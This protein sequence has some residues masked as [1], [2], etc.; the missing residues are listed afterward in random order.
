MSVVSNDASQSA[1]AEDVATVASGRDEGG[2]ESRWSQNAPSWAR[3]ADAVLQ[4]LDVDPTSGLADAAAERRLKQHGPNEL[5]R[6]KKR[7]I[8]SVAAAQ[9]KS[10]I[11]LLLIAAAA[12][13]FLFGETIEGWA[14][15]V[16]V[17]INAALGFV[18]QLRAVR[19]ME[20]LFKLGRVMCRARRNGEVVEI[21]ARDLVP[22]DVVLLEG[23][24][25]VSADMRLISASQLQADESALTGESLPTAKSVE[26]VDDEAPLADRRSMLY[27]GTG[28]TRGS[29]EGV[30]VGTGVHSELGR[31]SELIS[32]TKDEPT[33]LERRL[34]AL[35]RKL[36]W[37]TLAIA[38]LVVALG[39]IRGKELFLMIE[40]GIA[41][42]VASIPEGLPIVATI[43]LAR[44]VR[45]MARRHALINRLAAVETLGSA[46][47]ICTDKTGTLTENRMTVVALAVE[48][49]DATIDE[50][51]F[52]VDGSALTP[53]DNN[54]LRAAIEVALLCNNASITSDGEAGDPLEVA[55]L[56]V[57][58]AGEID[59]KDLLRKQP[60][61]REEAFDSEVKMMATVHEDGA[62]RSD[63]SDRT[64][65]DY[66]IAVKGAPE[67]VLEAAS[68]I[69]IAD[70]ARSLDDA[71]RDGWS[72]KNEALA[73]EGLR[74]I[75]LA[76]KYVDDRDA[77]PYTDLTFI[78]LVGMADPPRPEVA[79]AVQTCRRAGIQVVMVTGDQLVT[80]KGVAHAVG[81]V[82]T[83]DPAA[84]HGADLAAM[85]TFADDEKARLLDTSIFARV[86]PEQK[87]DLIDLH[88]QNGRIVAMTGD[89]VNDAPALK[90]ADIGIAMGIRG[91]QVAREA[92]DMVLQ[93]DSFATIVAAVEEG[94]I[95]FGNIRRFVFYLLSCNVSEVLVVGLATLLGT[96][97]PILPL[98]ILFLNLVTDIFPA[99]ALG[100]GEGPAR[101]MDVPPRDPKDPILKRRH[102]IDIGWYAGVITLAVL[103][104]LLLAQ[105]WLGIGSERAVTVSFLTLALAQLWHVFN[106][107]SWGSRLISN[108]ITRNRYIWMA[109]GLCLALLG[110]AVY[111]EPLAQVLR[112]V[113]PTSIEWALIVLMSFV[114]LVL[115]QLGRFIRGW[116]ESPDGPNPEPH[117][118]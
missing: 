53:S 69:H 103:G 84:I 52:R 63:A 74:V 64:G 96:T 32:E 28:I 43:A 86:S 91:T 68:H 80:A 93:D 22:G 44:G 101:V 66:R 16:V 51:V 117:G 60:R 72:R 110:G 102:W 37:I 56:R 12:V 5:R 15:A 18:T 88:Q 106:M 62:A 105:G 89:G 42:A 41:L 10:L 71:V 45:R 20:A 115:G 59:Q 99:L 100:T 9:F 46:G 116:R 112:I 85:E 1:Y 75:A 26:P 11:V 97:L 24:D 3:P 17:L 50:G 35:G 81:L 29:A 31:I 34:D 49:A 92:A 76:E 79:E 57:A 58:A 114:P 109:I 25:V 90:K 111:L 38:V 95:I 13:A 73:A 70:G 113:R 47:V 118:H 27:K 21:S 83:D 2:G 8:W 14:I 61:V 82:D 7:S 40:T 77:S 36:I 78:G 33:P 98:Q 108:E 4:E 39:L 48:D 65:G 94:R 6:R 23:G 55:L 67:A 87:L 107:R 104:A 54:R 19:S 30:V